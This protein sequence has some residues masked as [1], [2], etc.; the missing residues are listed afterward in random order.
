MDEAAVEWQKERAAAAL[1]ELRAALGGLATAPNA[2]EIV[3][4]RLQERECHLS[5]PTP[6]ERESRQVRQS[7]IAQ[8]RV[9]AYGEGPP[10]GAPNG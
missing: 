9:E 2:A 4:A 5:A 3:L 7:F 1:T 10:G 8:L 6:K